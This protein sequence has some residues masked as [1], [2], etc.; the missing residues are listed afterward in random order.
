MRARVAGRRWRERHA[1]VHGAEA[2]QCVFEVVAEEQRDGAPA[3]S[4]IDDGLADVAREA[5]AS[6]YET[7]RHPGTVAFGEECAS[8]ATSAQ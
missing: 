2:E 6:A 8:G 7:R 4:A 5:S 3:K 1:R